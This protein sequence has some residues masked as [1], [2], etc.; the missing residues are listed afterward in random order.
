MAVMAMPM[1]VP[2]YL[3]GLNLGILLVDRC[4]GARI[5]QRHRLGGRSGQDQQSADCSKSQ[6]FRY[7]HR[8]PPLGSS[9]SRHRR[10]ADFVNRLAATQIAKVEK[11]REWGMN[12]CATEL[13]AVDA[14]RFHSHDNNLTTVFKPR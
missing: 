8:Y 14:K 13:N 1:A 7:V 12:A 9:G 10:A 6:K 2:A 3:G 11:R 5:G 4:G